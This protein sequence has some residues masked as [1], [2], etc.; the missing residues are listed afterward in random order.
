MA[1]AMLLNVMR[2]VAHH[3]PESS[4]GCVLANLHII[5]LMQINI[6]ITITTVVNYCSY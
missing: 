4:W 6:T 5:V 1:L 2:V 3:G